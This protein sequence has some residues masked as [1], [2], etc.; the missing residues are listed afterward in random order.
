VPVLGVPV[1]TTVMVMAVTV[2]RAAAAGAPSMV[3]VLG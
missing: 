1:S 2:A 3:P